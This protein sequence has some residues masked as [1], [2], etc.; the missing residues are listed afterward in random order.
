MGECTFL[1]KFYRECR[2]NYSTIKYQNCKHFKPVQNPQLYQD[3]YIENSPKFFLVRC[4]QK[5]R[6]IDGISV[7][8]LNYL[9]PVKK[10]TRSIVEMFFKDK[11]W[12]KNEIYILYEI[13]I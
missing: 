3:G 13:V 8:A 12:L 4:I 1:K 11:N 6:K 10:M 5:H 7:H 9:E 2:S